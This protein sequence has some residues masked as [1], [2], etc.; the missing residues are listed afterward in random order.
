MSQPPLNIDNDPH[1]GR[2]SLSFQTTGYDPLYIKLKRLFDVNDE[3]RR[4]RVATN[5]AYYG[6]AL[7]PCV[8]KEYIT[9]ATREFNNEYYS[10]TNTQEWSVAQNPNRQ[11]DLDYITSIG[12]EKD[13]P[14][15]AGIVQLEDCCKQQTPKKE[16]HQQAGK[17]DYK[18]AYDPVVSDTLDANNA[19][20]VQ[21]A[22][23]QALIG[24]A[25]KQTKQQ[26]MYPTAY[27]T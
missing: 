1:I 4:Q 11:K 3:E 2:S 15:Y 9:I 13:H 20:D 10:Q 18:K 8:E 25:K 5:I 23:L 19:F 14:M 22:F 7:R 26:E 12:E 21:R 27:L 24:K 17:K 6:G 16:Y